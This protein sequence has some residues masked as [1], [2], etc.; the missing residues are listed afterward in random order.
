[1]KDGGLTCVMPSVICR[2]MGAEFVIGC[3][4]WAYSAFLRRFGLDDVRK[5]GKHLLPYHYITAVESTDLLIRPTITVGSH[6]PSA[7]SI[8]RL[9]A[10]G[11][12]AARE[13]IT[14]TYTAA[15]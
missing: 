10:A 2:E 11:E 14:A 15:A 6:I 8:D 4:V 9:I 7:V 1:M 13:A 3:D 5:P 12:L